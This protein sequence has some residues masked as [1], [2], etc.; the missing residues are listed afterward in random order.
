MAIKAKNFRLDDR[1]A[2]NF[3]V[4]CQELGVVQE[5]TVEALLF[6]AMKSFNA[7]DIGA[8]LKIAKEWKE[9]DSVNRPHPDKSSAEEGGAGLSEE[10]KKKLRNTA[11]QAL[12]Q[13][14]KQ[15]RKSG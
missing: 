6:Y 4:Y 9:G 11:R 10:G 1:I 5:R 12:S 13:E 15:N 3:A 8:F 2:D 14:S 7:Q